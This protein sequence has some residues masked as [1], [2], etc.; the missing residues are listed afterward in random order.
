[1]SSRELRTILQNNL[2]ESIFRLNKLLSGQNLGSVK[3]I[4]KRLG[5]NQTL[6]HWYQQL[7]AAQSLPNLDGKTIGS[8]I[9]MLFVSVLE[10]FTY[11]T[12]EIGELTINPAKGVDIPEL[13]LGIKS[14]SENFCTSEPF[15]SAY[16]R[17]LGNEHD[18]V[19]LLT[20]Y[21]TAKKKPPLKI[22]IIKWQYLK[23]SQIADRNLCRLAKI[24]REWLYNENTAQAKKVLRFLAYINQQDWQAKHLLKMIEVLDDDKSII[25]RIEAAIKH[26]HTKNLKN[27]K[28]GKELIPIDALN[29]ITRIKNVS[30]LYLGVIQAAD[31][32]I[33]NT[34]K[35]FARIPNDNEW[36]RYLSSPLDG[37]IGMSFA[38]QWRYNFASVFKN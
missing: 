7:K 21:Q 30:P 10:T 37:M 24:H 13:G 2:D 9:E 11:R 15:F 18:A 36:N 31:D 8:V 5:R 12:D 35:D 28:V 25:N 3:P 16:D 34:H 17:L 33:I 38:L 32:W 26:Y 20:D 27:E 4:L 6:P 19:I 22:K 29:T 23:G 1:M 14:P